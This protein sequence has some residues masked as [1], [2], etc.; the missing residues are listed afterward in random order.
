MARW[1]LSPQEKQN[2]RETLGKLLIGPQYDPNRSLGEQLLERL[3]GSGPTYQGPLMRLLGATQQAEQKPKSPLYPKPDDFAGDWDSL[4]EQEKK[5]I[6]EALKSGRKIYISVPQEE[7][8]RGKLNGITLEKQR[9]QK[10][11]TTEW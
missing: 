5:A 1:D 4:S 11:L 7:G 9:L 3:G 2:L 6:Y 10:V 8:L